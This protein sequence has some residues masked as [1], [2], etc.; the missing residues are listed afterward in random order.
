[1]RDRRIDSV[2]NH[3]GYC[4][5]TSPPVKIKNA[6]STVGGQCNVYH[7]NFVL[8]YTLT[9]RPTKISGACNRLGANESEPLISNDIVASS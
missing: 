8:A 2:R 7:V 5:T 9:C 6:I 1:M 3:T 4:M